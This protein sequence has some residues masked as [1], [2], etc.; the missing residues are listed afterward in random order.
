MATKNETPAEAD[1]EEAEGADAKDAAAPKPRP[2]AVKILL[3][4]AALC[5]PSPQSTGPGE[6]CAAIVGDPAEP[7]ESSEHA[8]IYPRFQPVLISSTE[9]LLISY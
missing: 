7:V 6:P 4:L 3:T 8:W 1:K 5:R 2:G 9:S